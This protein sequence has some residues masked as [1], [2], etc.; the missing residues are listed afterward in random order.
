MDSTGLLYLLLAVSFALLVGVPAF[1]YLRRGRRD[2]FEPVYVG[3]L[4]FSLMFWVRSL[5]V[6]WIGSELIGEA[7][8]SADLVKAWNLAW[9][10]LILATG[11]FFASYY[12]HLGKSLAKVFPR[13]G[14]EWKHGAARSM[15]VL[16][17]GCGLAAVYSLVGR[18]GGLGQFLGRRQDT[19]PTLGM[20][21]A[22]VELLSYCVAL[23][24]FA[25]YIVFLCRR[26]HLGTFLFLLAAALVVGL[27]AGSRTYFLYPI[28]TLLLIDHYLRK[29][30]KLRHLVSLGL[31]AALIISPLVIVF[32]EGMTFHE[33]SSSEAV[34]GRAGLPSFI[35][36]FAG[37]ES[38]LLIIRDTPA[39]MDYQYGKTM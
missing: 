26:K 18:Y 32:R 33:I 19:E 23:S 24:A 37:V 6:L 16:L 30:K 35:E 11:V 12:S 4:V 5:R 20:G 3:T 25:A 21:V 17:F 29:P 39:V 22:D 13:L 31:I 7:P 8:F 14:T 36:R 34:V 15:I 28:A 1:Q 2:L 38:L 9:I 10:Y 27:V